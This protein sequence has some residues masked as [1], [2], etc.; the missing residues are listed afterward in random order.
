MLALKLSH[1][2]LFSHPRITL[3]FLLQSALIAHIKLLVFPRSK[4]F[5]EAGSSTSESLNA[6]YDQFLLREPPR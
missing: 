4:Y 1:A 3:T 6:F 2:H 5:S